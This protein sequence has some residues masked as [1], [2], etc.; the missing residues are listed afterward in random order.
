MLRIPQTLALLL[1]G[2]VARDAPSARLELEFMPDL[3][4]HAA[5]THE[6]ASLWAEHGVSITAALDEVFGAGLSEQQIK[7]VVFEG[8]SASGRRGG[9]MRLRAS[10]PLDV[11]L[12]TLVHELSHRYMVELAGLHCFDEV[13]DPLSV[14]LAEVWEHLWGREFVE[15][16]AAVESRRSARYERSW[17]RA[18]ALSQDARRRE[19]ASIIATAR[20]CLPRNPGDGPG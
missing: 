5:A 19:L 15:E 8:I 3:Q 2:L 18:L 1:L 14:V 16:Q 13:H 17:S 12:A 6:Y 10:Y 11:K 4:R 20:S 9:P 7:V